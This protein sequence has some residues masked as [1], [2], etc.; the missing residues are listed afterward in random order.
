MLQCL[1]FC[2]LGT[3]RSSEEDSAVFRR[4]INKQQNNGHSPI[5][6]N[7][8]HFYQVSKL[9]INTLSGS[10]KYPYLPTEGYQKF[11]EVGFM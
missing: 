11:Q 10:R 3:V 1:L 8:T 6:P 2:V 9:Q 4:A 7:T 5:L